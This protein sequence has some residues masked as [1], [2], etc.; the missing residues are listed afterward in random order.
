[1]LLSRI[2]R[3]MAGGDANAARR[4]IERELFEPLGFG[5]A[6]LV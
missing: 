3:D 4:F 2:I 6:T 1:V 5:H